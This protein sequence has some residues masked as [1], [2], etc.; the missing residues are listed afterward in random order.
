MFAAATSGY[1]E[2][3]W[4]T[5]VML[6]SVG[7]LKS[8]LSKPSAK[9]FFDLRTSRPYTPVSFTASLVSDSIGTLMTLYPTSVSSSSGL[10][11]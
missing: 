7:R 5:H 11:S 8:Q 2:N 4:L 6:G 9:K 3:F 10:A 1:D